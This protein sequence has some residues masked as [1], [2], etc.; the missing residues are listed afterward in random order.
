M[1]N[2]PDG[3]PDRIPID[4]YLG[5]DCSGSMG[6]PAH[7][8]SYPVVAG[9]II[10]LS[11]LRSGSKVKVALSGE[12][13]QT[14]TTDGF[15]RQS[16]TILQTLTDYLGTGYAFGIHRLRETFDVLPRGARPIHILVISDNDMFSMLD[17]NSG[18]GESGWDV[19]ARAIDK[20]GGGADL[21]A[22]TARSRS[23][24]LLE[25]KIDRLLGENPDHGLGR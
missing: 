18:D 2:S 13:G 7:H 6:N 24:R 8:L 5:V 15:L 1:G 25:T 11:A 17:E 20:A 4:L 16:S 21:R 12:P 3:D 22:R 23:Q 19:A 9:A 10:A 14:K